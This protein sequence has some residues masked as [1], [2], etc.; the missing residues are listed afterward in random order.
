MSARFPVPN[1]RI[2]AGSGIG[3]PP[4]TVRA[5]RIEI[6]GNMNLSWSV[7]PPPVA[8]VSYASRTLGLVGWSRFGLLT[9]AWSHANAMIR[10][11]NIPF[12]RGLPGQIPCEGSGCPRTSY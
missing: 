7:H 5:L 4:G 12:C 3:V 10:L 8:N 6:H 9:W 2:E 1:S 11:K